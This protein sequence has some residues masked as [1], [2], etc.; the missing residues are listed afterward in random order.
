[1]SEA[2]E[3]KVIGYQIKPIRQPAGMVYTQ[4]FIL[5]NRCMKPISSH[6]GPMYDAICI[7]CFNEINHDLSL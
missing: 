4:A 3:S 5:C 2:N 1:M 7:P 6:G